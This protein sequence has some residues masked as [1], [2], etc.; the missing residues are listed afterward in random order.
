[1][2]LLPPELQWEVTDPR[3]E[4]PSDGFMRTPP[5]AAPPPEPPCQELQHP[6]H[7]VL[8]PLPQEDVVMSQTIRTAGVVRVTLLSAWWKI[9]KVSGERGVQTANPPHPPN[10]PPTLLPFN[11]C[12]C[13]WSFQKPL[14]VMRAARLSSA[15]KRLAP[16]WETCLCHYVGRTTCQTTAACFLLSCFVKVKWMVGNHRNQNKS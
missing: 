7:A 16:V 6:L 15:S 12:I 3:L 9:A 11:L 13:V 10:P 1:M 2:V 4:T 5:S 8:P 14:Q